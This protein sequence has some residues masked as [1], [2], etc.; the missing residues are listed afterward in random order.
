[1][2]VWAEPKVPP[3]LSQPLESGV[4]ALSSLRIDSEL[5]IHQ[6]KGGEW[7]LRIV[8]L[9]GDSPALHPCA[10][11]LL[12]GGCFPG[13]EARRRIDTDRQGMS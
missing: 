13:G 2:G 7:R 12:S 11:S 1:M 5:V 6:G 10:D 8:T 4:L 9:Q 3:R